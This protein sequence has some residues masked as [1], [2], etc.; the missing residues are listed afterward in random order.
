LAA[1]SLGKLCQMAIFKFSPAVFLW[2]QTDGMPQQCLL[3][4]GI[5]TKP[6]E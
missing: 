6:A 1:A 4:P 2:I 3:S 5:T